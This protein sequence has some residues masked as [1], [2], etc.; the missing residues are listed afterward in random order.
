M[1][2]S[3]EMALL[4]DE[5]LRS[6]F[7]ET[8]HSE[9][10]NL[11]ISLAIVR[12]AAKRT[13][14][15]EP[16]E[17]Q[18]QGAAALFQ[19]VVVEMKTGEGKTLTVA[20]AAAIAAASKQGVHVATVNPYLAQRDAE[21]MQPLFEFLGLTVGVTLPNLSNVEKQEAYAADITY[22]VHSELGFDY[23]R[24][25]LVLRDEDKVQRG[26]AFVIVDEADSI[27]IDEARTPLVISQPSSVEANY[28]NVADDIVRTLSVGV[29][30]E[31]DEKLH[32]AVLTEAGL[33]KVES[34]LLDRTVISHRGALYESQNLHLLRFLS[35]AMKAY[36]LFRRDRDYIVQNGTIQII[37][38]GTGRILDGRQW[39]DGLHQAIEAKEGVDIKPEN[40]TAAEITY[41]S[42]F[43]LYKRLS[44]L[45]GTAQ[46]SAEEFEGMY[47][48]MVVPIPTHRKVIRIDGQDQLFRTKAHKF[49]AIVTDIKD[50][51]ANGQP[52][53]IGTASVKES[54]ELSYWLT[55]NQLPHNVLNARQNELEAKV[56][57]DAGMPGVITV[58][59]NMAG[60]G[61]DIVLGGHTEKDDAWK[62]RNE[63]V[64]KAGGLHVIGT[65]RNESRRVDDQLRGRAG[66]QGDPGSSQF[67]LCLEDDLIRIFGSDRLERLFTLTGIQDDALTG[68]M[69][70]KA[71]RTAQGRVEG[72]H[73]ESR[74]NLAKFD[75]VMAEQREAVYTLRRDILQGDVKVDYVEELLLESTQILVDTYINEHEFS[76]RWNV[77]ELKK[78]LEQDLG[79]S[80]PVI[81][82]VHVDSLEYRDILDRVKEGVLAAYREKRLEG[83][84]LTPD[85]RSYLVRTV[86]QLWRAHLT[87]LAS[88]REGIHL[89]SYAQVDPATAFR[90]DAFESFISFRK[91]LVMQASAALTFFL[92]PSPL[93]TPH[94]PAPVIE[95]YPDPEQLV[96][97]DSAATT[98]YRKVARNDPCPCGSGF[99]YKVCHGKLT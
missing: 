70:D 86:D 41:Q 60:R 28:Y 66:R 29:D 82:W 48:L 10:R 89:R 65:T 30:F 71:V 61:T 69:L 68:N 85:E 26:L 52:I 39:Q 37:D 38:G 8:K 84:E 35:A 13:I 93:V 17:V 63:T 95:V 32:N 44:G 88:L 77:K 20:L 51:I 92:K 96:T 94:T 2:L 83:E 81:K 58:A 78:A 42:L 40:E 56:I 36:T 24:D 57:A 22:G 12:E 11:A 64:I 73:F 53:L 79:V 50:R 16:Y 97:P 33:D 74:K 87:H 14:G 19:G 45:T 62:V 98:G 6:R 25:H 21:S 43:K 15:M 67:Y 72:Q 7:Y 90:K 34:A 9:G 18:L 5:A 91:N 76:E 23:L 49:S 59:T 4:S 99:R 54:D 46:T 75:S 31:V 80:L 55:Q 47:G 27:L 3:N 1:A